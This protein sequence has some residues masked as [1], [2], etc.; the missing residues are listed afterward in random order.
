MTV[1]KKMRA[2][3]KHTVCLKKFLR[4]ILFSSVIATLLFLLNY[5]IFHWW[6]EIPF[7]IFGR[8]WIF[9]FSTVFL[10]FLAVAVGMQIDRTFWRCRFTKTEKQAKEVPA[11]VA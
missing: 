1:G 2:F 5:R 11:Y 8:A 10:T 9:E 4:T 7:T 3:F 6:V